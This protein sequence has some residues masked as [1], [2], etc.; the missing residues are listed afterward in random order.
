MKIPILLSFLTIFIF[1]ACQSQN[2]DSPPGYDLNH[3]KVYR[4]P[5]E[6][7]EISGIA[8][9]DSIND[10]IYAEQ[11]EEGTIYSIELGG[12]YIGKATFKDHGDFEDIGIMGEEVIMLRSNGKMYGIP[13]NEMRK[14]KI[15]TVTK[16]HH[17]LPEGEFEGLYA[18]NESRKVYVLCKNCKD[19][20]KDNKKVTGFILKMNKLNELKRDGKFHLN[21]EKIAQLAGKDEVNFKP[22]ALA[23]NKSS[24]LWYVLSSKNKMLVIANK[25]WKIKAV[26]LLDPHLYHQPEGLIF[27]KDQN[28]YI[29]NEGAKHRLGTIYK[30]PFQPQTVNE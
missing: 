7:V 27:D 10:T 26:Y 4:M 2:F 11:D 19:I 13:I 5:D 14:G 22:S 24:G 28:L 18:N 9:Y 30:F 20:D 23:F 21:S 15:S 6:L 25:N 1:N 8:F 16:W 12:S 29:S 3:P 17:L